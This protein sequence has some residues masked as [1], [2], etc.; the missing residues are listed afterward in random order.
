MQLAGKKLRPANIQ[1]SRQS[2][3]PASSRV[4]ARP[5]R[6]SA[7]LHVPRITSLLVCPKPG[8]LRH[9]SAAALSGL[10]GLL[11]PRRARLG[12]VGRPV[13]A[14]SVRLPRA[15]HDWPA[16]DRGS[17]VL[18]NGLPRNVGL[19]AAFQAP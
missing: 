14:P 9:I 15:R 17:C 1:A 8:G 19:T 6:K 7:S 18:R 13:V 3:D 10:V 16:W 11:P 5:N 2:L 12:I 4:A